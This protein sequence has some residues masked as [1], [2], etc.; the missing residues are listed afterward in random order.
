M[1]YLVIANNRYWW[2]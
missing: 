2:E 1:R